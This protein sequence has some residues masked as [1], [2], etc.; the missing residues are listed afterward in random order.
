MFSIGFLFFIS[1][2]RTVVVQQLLDEIDV[3]QEHSSA[4]VALEAE[5]VQCLPVHSRAMWLVAMVKSKRA[6]T[7]TTPP[8]RGVCVCGGGGGNRAC[9]YVLFSV[10]CLHEVEVVLP[11]VANDLAAGEAAVVLETA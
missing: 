10:V 3:G 6:P 7:P 8:P 1:I 11:L 5:G 9:L 2:G 4:A